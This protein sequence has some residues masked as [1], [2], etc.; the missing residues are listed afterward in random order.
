MTFKDQLAEDL[1]LTL[2]ADEVDEP[3]EY[4]PV[5][6]ATSFTVRIVRGDI[7]T[8][9]AQFD[10]GTEHTRTCE[11][12][13]IRSVVRAGILAIESTARDPKRGDKI[14]FTDDSDATAEWF[15]TGPGS[16]DVGGGVN[17]T[18]QCDDY[19]N[20]GGRSANEVR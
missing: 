8:A 6:S 19:G 7:Q 12:T 16:V 20:P 3:A 9:V 4:Y 1:R 14:T 2:N 5:D 13:L 10:Q 15:V 11:A 17:V 18:L